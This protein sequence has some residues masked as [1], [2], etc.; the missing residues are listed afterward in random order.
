LAGFR[1]NLVILPSAGGDP[2]GLTAEPP[3][4]G[5]VLWQT[6]GVPVVE[7]QVFLQV[8]LVFG[9][10]GLLGL[11]LRWTFRR[12]PERPAP[13]RSD[14]DG[15]RRSAFRLFRRS[16]RSARPDPRPISPP[17]DPTPDAPAG[18]ATH[19]HAG[20]AKDS[21]AK[22]GDAVSM[23]AAAKDAGVTRPGTRDAG[24]VSGSSLRGE[25][26]GLLAVAADTATAEEAAKV[27]QALTVAGIRCTSTVT[28][29]GRHKVLVFGEELMRA[30]RVAGG[31]QGAGGGNTGSGGS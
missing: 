21:G 13:S 29:E 5:M 31:S 27:K 7:G 9:L 26:Y 16:R 28:G 24:T 8:A 12:A 20:D 3:G 25:D 14:A 2:L 30:R 23:P 6:D 1:R 4:T 10:I 15:R 11:V 17:A 18:A 19:A 22:D